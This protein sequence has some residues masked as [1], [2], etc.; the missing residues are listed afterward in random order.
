MYAS[1]GISSELIGPVRKRLGCLKGLNL[2]CG[3][4]VL[5]PTLTQK[6]GMRSMKSDFVCSLNEVFT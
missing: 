4:Q 2:M 6:N 1:K 3:V 5:P